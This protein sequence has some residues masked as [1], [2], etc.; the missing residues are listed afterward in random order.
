MRA[1]GMRCRS[2]FKVSIDL[3]A[4]NFQSQGKM[5]VIQPGSGPSL[6]D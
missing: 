1:G 5:S 6:L 2:H 4:L 3:Q